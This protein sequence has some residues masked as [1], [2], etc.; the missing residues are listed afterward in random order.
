LSTTDKILKFHQVG[1]KLAN[2]QLVPCDVYDKCIVLGLLSYRK[3][4]AL[5]TD[6]LQMVADQLDPML[7]SGGLGGA[8][9]WASL[10]SIRA[11]IMSLSHHHAPRIHL[12]AWQMCMFNKHLLNE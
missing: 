2:R 4:S 1:Y 5:H 11:W 9:G 7:N 8:G 12:I 3:G 6:H 10:S